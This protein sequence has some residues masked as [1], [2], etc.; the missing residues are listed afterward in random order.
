[1]LSVG[2]ACFL[3]ISDEPIQRIHPGRVVNIN[4][5]VYTVEL[6]ETDL[7]LHATDEILVFYNL[8]R[9]FVKQAARISGEVCC[10]PPAVVS[11]ETFGEAVSAEKREFYRVS[12][13]MAG[14]AVEFGTESDCPLLDVSATGFAVSATQ[15]HG[16]ARVVEVVL[17]DDEEPFGGQV[18][19]RSIR[20]LPNGRIRYG[21][22]CIDDKATPNLLTGVRR[23]STAVQR[24]QLR[25]LSAIS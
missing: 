13:V 19:I 4:D 25:R 14:H 6:E 1:M 12:T 9:G 8:K 24:E 23:L 11:F 7:P 21:V 10:G 22:N 20:M 17:C 18:V 15:E 5:G 3:Q 16:L 2:K